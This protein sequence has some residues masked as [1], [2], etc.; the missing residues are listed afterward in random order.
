MTL[1]DC[2]FDIDS[3]FS[4]CPVT[5]IDGKTIKIHLDR[6]FYIG[7]QS[8]QKGN[9]QEL[10]KSNP[11]SHRQNQKGKKHAHKFINANKRHAQ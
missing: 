8:K 11:T 2:W 1:T 6:Y 5:Y 4:G 9:G 3:A 10:I 7:N